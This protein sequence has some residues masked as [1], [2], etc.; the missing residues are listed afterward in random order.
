M[1]LDVASLTQSIDEMWA[2]KEREIRRM[3]VDDT[4][5]TLILERARDFYRNVVNAIQLQHQAETGQ[6]VPRQLPQANNPAS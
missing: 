5:K 4:T 3:Y 1:A 2:L 6:P